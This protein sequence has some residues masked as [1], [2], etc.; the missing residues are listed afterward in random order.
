MIP[1][2]SEPLFASNSDTSKSNETPNKGQSKSSR[3]DF[4][5]LM[6]SQVDKKG[7]RV[8]TDDEIH[9][10]ADGEELT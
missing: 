6:R 10:I 8:L 5:K 4:I 7:N 2:G 3:T 1:L 9:E